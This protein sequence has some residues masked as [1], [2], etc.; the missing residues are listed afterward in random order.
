MAR[1][2]KDGE[3]ISL[4]VDRSVMAELR[5]YAADRGQTLTMALER[6]VRAHLDAE[7]QRRGQGRGDAEANAL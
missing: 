4:Y 2:K 3:K 1:A 6:I 7:A 5:A